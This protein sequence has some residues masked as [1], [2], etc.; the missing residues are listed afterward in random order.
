MELEAE[1]EEDDDEAAVALTTQGYLSY[2]SYLN[3]AII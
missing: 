3:P 2:F 1:E